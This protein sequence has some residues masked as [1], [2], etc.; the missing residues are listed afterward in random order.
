VILILTEPRDPHADRVADELRARG[1]PFVRFDPADF[2]RR[3]EITI[4]NRDGG[5]FVRT[6]RTA[7]AELDL[8]SGHASWYRRPGTPVPDERLHDPAA[9]AYV[10]VECDMLVQ[11]LWSSLDGAWLPGH[12]L[13]I[14]KA[15][16]KTTQLDLAARLGFQLPPTLVTNRPADL[17]DFYRQHDGKIISKLAATAF[18]ATIG[19][20][21]VRY[22]ELVTPRDIAHHRD[23]AGCPMIFQAYVEKR[24]EL[25]ITVVGKRVFAAEI[26][27]QANHHTRFDW[28]RYD[29]TRTTHLPHALPPE[30]ERQCLA[31]VERLGLRYGAIDMIVTPD[32]RYVFLEIN[33][34]GQYLW[35]EQ[36]TELPITAAICDLLMEGDGASAGGL[37]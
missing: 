3:A 15:D 17:L 35:I 28:R 22:T 7:D 31:L 5:R 33:P 25:R 18:P 34:N 26:H 36:K 29:L 12:P 19:F 11:D 10:Q 8:A 20:E 27:S 32:G 24:V 30:I 21:T 4:S 1:A 6:L 14:H 13:A 9:R 23:I 2:P 37:S 16:Q